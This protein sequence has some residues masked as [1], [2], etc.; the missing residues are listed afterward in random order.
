MTR[1]KHF[2]GS[3]AGRA[4][5]ALVLVLAAGLVF[6]ADGAFFRFSTHRDA[7]RQT[8]VYGMLA[9]GLTLVIICGGIDLAVG[10]VLALVAVDLI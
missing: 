4:T 6:N 3:A 2:L 10:S 5:I 9:C 8:S 1:L 7:L